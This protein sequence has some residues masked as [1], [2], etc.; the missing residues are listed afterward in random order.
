MPSRHGW[1]QQLGPK[2][3]HAWLLLCIRLVART[4][5]LQKASAK[6][7]QAAASELPLPLR[8]AA[9]LP[10]VC[11]RLGCEQPIQ[12][13]CLGTFSKLR[14]RAAVGPP[15][16]GCCLGEGDTATAALVRR[17][18]RVPHPARSC[19]ETLSLPTS[20]RSCRLRASARS[21]CASDRARSR[22]T[23]P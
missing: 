11:H 15:R 17:S 14:L 1:C 6:V 2:P 4:L 5:K 22:A 8:T 10:R 12:Q 16:V 21:C 3:S 9:L 7:L 13:F 19:W 20:C 23:S 18:P